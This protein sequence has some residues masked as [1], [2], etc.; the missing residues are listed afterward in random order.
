MTTTSELKARLEDQ[1]EELNQIAHRIEDKVEEITD[2]KTFVKRRPFLSVGIGIGLGILFSGAA[3]P[4]VKASYQQA[5]STIAATSVA[6]VA[7]LL[8]NWDPTNAARRFL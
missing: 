1:S 7:S 5:T 4:V 6:Y 8:K 2:W 3:K